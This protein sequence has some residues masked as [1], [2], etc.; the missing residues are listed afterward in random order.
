MIVKNGNMVATVWAESIPYWATASNVAVLSLEKGDQVSHPMGVKIRAVITT[1][2]LTFGKVMFLLMFVCL[3]GGLPSHNTMI[4][5]RAMGILL[6][7]ILVY[8]WSI[9]SFL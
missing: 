8:N 9:S 5:R 6:E 4:N 1:R 7:C 3:R 2:K